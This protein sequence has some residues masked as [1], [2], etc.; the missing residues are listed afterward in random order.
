VPPKVLPTNE[1]KPPVEGSTR[2]NWASVL[3]SSA[4]AMPATMIVSGAA[5]PAVTTR[6][7]N[8]KKKL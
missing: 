7:A 6:K 3:P 1:M 2:E 4:M 5:I 8:P